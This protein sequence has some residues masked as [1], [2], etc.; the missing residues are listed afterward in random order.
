MKPAPL[1]V[2]AIFTAKAGLEADLRTALRAMV[3]PTRREVGCLNYDLHSSNHEP[4]LLFFHET[5]A[6]AQHHAAHL[7]TPHVRHL[8][9]L[10]PRLLAEPIRELKG[11]RLEEA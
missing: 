7:E 2:V 6:S 10:T 4:G 11:A 1:V 9:T 5:W 3:E 8:L